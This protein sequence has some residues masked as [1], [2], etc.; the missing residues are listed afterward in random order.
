MIDFNQ[1][2]DLARRLSDLVPPGL[3]QSREELQSTF[4]GALQAG[5]GKLDLVTRE[6]FDVQRAVL[7]RTR[8][9]L[10]ALEQT[11]AA[12]EARAPGAPPAAP[13]TIP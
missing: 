2:D 12:L 10:D 4:K 6:E 13:P 9:K 7:L 3:R 11:V 8:E 1:L 5:L